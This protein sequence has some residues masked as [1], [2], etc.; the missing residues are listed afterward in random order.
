MKFLSFLV[1]VP[2]VASHLCFKSAAQFQNAEVKSCKT[3]YT[4]LVNSIRL[5]KG[6]ECFLNDIKIVEK[7]GCRAEL[8]PFLK[9]HIASCETILHAFSKVYKDCA[10]KSAFGGYNGYQTE[11]GVFLQKMPS[12]HSKDFADGEDEIDVAYPDEN[13]EEYVEGSIRE[14]A[15]DI[16]EKF[17][18][19]QGPKWRVQA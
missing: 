12:G 17:R 3:A 15:W 11:F 5:D 19:L 2:I 18:S 14:A 9:L 4:S 6:N 1:L 16:L 8:S 13:D 10:K 7:E